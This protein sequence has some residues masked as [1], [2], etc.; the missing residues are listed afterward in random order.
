MKTKVA[1]AKFSREIF[2]HKEKGYNFKVLKYFTFLRK[3]KPLDKFS[4]KIKSFY[5]IRIRRDT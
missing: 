5:P 1:R 2:L 4:L 3:K